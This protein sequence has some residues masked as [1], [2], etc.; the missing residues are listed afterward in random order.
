MDKA[1]VSEGAP[2]HS[3][4]SSNISFE[5]VE[6]HVFD[7]ISWIN[8]L[9]GVYKLTIDRIEN[10]F[11]MDFTSVD[12]SLKFWLT[13]NPSVFLNVSQEC[14]TTIICYVSSQLSK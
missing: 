6:L 14:S 2:V 10:G 11:E 8:T 4:V 13:D 7:K 9:I 5:D 3:V 1:E 12:T